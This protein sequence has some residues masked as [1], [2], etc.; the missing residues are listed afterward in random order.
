MVLGINHKHFTKSGFPSNITYRTNKNQ[1]NLVWRQYKVILQ[2]AV[3]VTVPVEYSVNIIIFFSISTIN[4]GIDENERFRTQ[5]L[6]QQWIDKEIITYETKIN[7]TCANK[8][9]TRGDIGFRSHQMIDVV[10]HRKT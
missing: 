4:H 2:V 3:P 10:S 8:G 1:R 5:A 7:Q 9:T 6:R